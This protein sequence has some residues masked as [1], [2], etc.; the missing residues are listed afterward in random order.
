MPSIKSNQAPSFGY[1]Q[2]YDFSKISNLKTPAPNAYNVSRDF[3]DKGNRIAS[4]GLSIG[5][6]REVFYEFFFIFPEILE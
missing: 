6:G 1:G 3:D 4:A 5:I 2:K